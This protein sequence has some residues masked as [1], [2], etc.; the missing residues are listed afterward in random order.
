VGVRSAE[1]SS[2]AGPSSATRKG[3]TVVVIVGDALGWTIDGVISGVVVRTPISSP[4][5]TTAG[6][7]WPRPGVGEP[8]RTRG[9]VPS[10]GALR[11]KQSPCAAKTRRSSAANAAST[12]GAPKE[13]DLAGIRTIAADIQVL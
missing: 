2:A 13:A 9:P 4:L 8:S 12:A 5:L 10:C 7:G 6:G 1:G 11:C 3:R